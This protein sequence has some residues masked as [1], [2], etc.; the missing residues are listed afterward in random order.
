MHDSD[1]G[2]PEPGVRRGHTRRKFLALAGAAGVV[3]LAGCGGGGG[4]GGGSDG[5]GDGG[6]GDG[7]SDGG[8][9]DGGSGGGDGGDGDGG[10]D[11]GSTDG[12][13]S[14]MGSVTVGVLNPMTG[15]YSS[16]GPGQRSGAELAVQQI[17]D[18]DEYSFELEPVYEDTGTEA[19]A[20]Q[21]SAQR[22]VQQDGAQFLFGAISSSVAL[23]LNQ[24]ADQ[25]EFVY[26]PGGAAVPITGDACSEWVF[27]VE[28]N[29]A[30]IAEAISAYTVENLGSNVWFHIADY[31]YGDSVYSRTSSRMQES[32]GDFTEVGKSASELGASNFGSYISQISN[33]EADAVVLGMTGG[34]LVNFVNQAANQGLKDQV[35]LVGP[36]MS[37]QTVRQATGANSVGT[38]G[39]VR[40]NAQ[41]ETGDNQAFVEAFRS[42][43]DSLPDNFERVGYDSLR[44]I[45]RGIQQAGSTDPGAV[46]DALSGGT[47]TTVL[48][49][50]TLREGDHQATN[51]TWMGEIV[52]G[53]GD[54]PQ[55]DLLSM[56]EGANTLPPASELGCDMG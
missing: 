37:F 27:R 1:S 56:V 42:A 52:A 48:G 2:V 21:Q 49:D 19:G 50:V 8:G 45:A 23:S 33:S 20:A 38:F 31:A 3:G 15:A 18:S 24:F 6:S 11:G 35:A 43:N 26:F 14:D 13:P 30:Q 47:F 36:T 39:G 29:T 54:V 32:S 34:D 46:R 10:S 5:G 41:L 28:T 9:G 25:S 16:L 53:D 44:L 7:G 17:N 22:V 40:Y 55:V 12:S 4:D 51:P